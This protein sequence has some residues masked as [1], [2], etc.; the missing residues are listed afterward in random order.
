MEFEKL[1]WGLEMKNMKKVGVIA[2]CLVL[3]GAGIILYKYSSRS[4]KVP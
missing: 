1:K 4:I 2:L 3:L